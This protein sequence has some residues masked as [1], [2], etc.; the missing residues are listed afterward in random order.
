M[1]V[2]CAFVDI[3]LHLNCELPVFFQK[4][5]Q[6]YCTVHILGVLVLE[7]IMIMCSNVLLEIYKKDDIL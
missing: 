2:T 7:G 4:V 6:W 1:W 5:L 3:V